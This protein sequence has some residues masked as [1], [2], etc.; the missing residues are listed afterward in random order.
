MDNFEQ[1]LLLIMAGLECQDFENY[2]FC[3]AKKSSEK[4]KAK[5]A[6]PAT[7]N[8]TKEI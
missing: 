8:L 1:K 2:L 5:P 6:S 3:N 4:K 7:K